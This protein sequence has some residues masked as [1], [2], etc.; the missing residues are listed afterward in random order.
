MIFNALTVQY[1]HTVGPTS[2][3]NILSKSFYMGSCCETSNTVMKNH[4]TF[5]KL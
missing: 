2:E 3:N 5:N 4:E 1:Q